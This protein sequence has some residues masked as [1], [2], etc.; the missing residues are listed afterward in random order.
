MLRKGGFGM[1]NASFP[2]YNIPEI[3]AAQSAFWKG[4][5]THLTR[6]GIRD[7]PSELSHG[8]PLATLL[9]DENMLL[10]QCCGYDVVSGYR[11]TL[12]TIATPVFDVSDC[13]G[14]EYSSLIIVSE[15]CPYQ[16]VLEMRGCAA[17]ANGPESHSG[18]NALRHLVAPKNINGSFFGSVVYSGGH[19]QS[20]KLIQDGRA[21]V[22]AID[23]VTHKLLE[24]YRPNAIKGTRILGRTFFA[25]A[26]PYVTHANRGTDVKK[27]IK[28][29]L[30]GAFSDTDLDACRSDLLLKRISEQD[31][32]IYEKLLDFEIYASKLG[33]PDLV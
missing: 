17:V 19:E 6:E 11:E 9:S 10:S 18:M 3:W 1:L 14:Y 5:A 8:Q 20:M 22:A 23:C 32:T 31:D 28:T 29:A 24:R 13:S 30:M 4:I 7:V 26:P 27:R 15:E 16:D 12:T 25:P 21:D 33:Y 2:M